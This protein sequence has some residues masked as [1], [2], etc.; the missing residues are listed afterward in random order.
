MLL[1]VLFLLYVS[2]LCFK[3][4][5]NLSNDEADFLLYLITVK[6]VHCYYTYIGTCAHPSKLLN[7]LV[8]AN[9]VLLNE[10]C[11]SK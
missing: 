2:S 1:F 3:E 4:K 11:I 10:L 9:S 7:R 6:I 5:S 8:L